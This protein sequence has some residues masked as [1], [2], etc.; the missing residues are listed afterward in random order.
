[1]A[2]AEGAPLRALISR[3]AW[4]L[5]LFTPVGLAALPAF[6]IEGLRE[7]WFRLLRTTLEYSGSWMGE[8]VWDR[9]GERERER[10]RGRVWGRAVREGAGRG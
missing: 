5:L 3:G 2:N 4:L 1:V 9:G 7:Y 10:G 6:F 8:W